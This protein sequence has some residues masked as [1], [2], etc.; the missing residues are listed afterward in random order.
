MLQIFNVNWSELVQRMPE[1]AEAGYDSLWLPPPAK[2]GSVFSVGYDLF[3]PFDLGDLNQRGTVATKYGSKAQLMQVIQTAHRFGIRV[4]L[5]N[6]V[7]HRGFDVP[8]YN[9]NTPTNLYPGLAPQDFHLQTV[10]GG[11]YVNWPDI[12]DFNTIWNIQNQPLSGL[13]DL[14][15]EPG[16]VNLNFGPT[17]GST[18]SKISYLRQPGNN[19]YYMDPALP[20]I[21][22]PWHPFNGSHGIPVVEDVNAYLMRSV[23]WILNETKCDGFRLDAVKHVPSGFFGDTSDTPNGYTGAIQAM[24]DYVHGYGSNVTGN[25][26]QETGGNRDSLFNTEA[27]RNDAL[28]FGEHLGQP[29]TFDEYLS[30]GMRLLNT[31]LANY[32][33]GVLGNPGGSLSGLDQRDFSP[34]GAYSPIQS[35]MYAQ[36]ADNGYAAHRELQNAYYFMHEGIPEVYSDGNNQTQVSPGQNAFPAIANANFLGQYADDAMPELCRL[37]HQFA[38]GGTWSRWSDTDIVAFER[39]DYR[40]G[41]GSNPQ[42]QDVALFAMND[43][44]GFP[45]DVSFDDGVSRSGDGYYGCGPVSN[46]RGVGLVVGF[47]PGTVLVQMARSSAG[48]DRACAHLLVH[49]A[50]QNKTLA[51]STANDPNPA[52]RLIYVGGQSLAQNGGALELLI[53]SGGY[54]IYALQPPEPSRAALA[55]TI[56]LRQQSQDAPRI[57]VFRQDGVNG[58]SNFN[59]AY[60]FRVRGSV[61]TSGNLL[62]MANV[63]NFTYSIDIPVVT[64]GPFD[65]MVKQD[66][67]AV[68]TLVKLD[69][70][71]DLN[72]Q[73]GL[74]GTNLNDLR[75]NPPGYAT[76]VFL[77]YE[78]ALIQLKSGPERFGS[79]NVASNNLVSPNAETFA[80]VVGG[81]ASVVTGS[82]FGAA[83]TNATARWVWHD[84]TNSVTALG[85]V[86]LTQRNP[87][88]PAAGQTV[89]IW[90]KVGYQFQINTGCL[91]YTTDG[92]EPLGSFGTGKGTTRMVPLVF[93]NHD[94]ATSSIDWWKGV[95]P[96]NAQI[97]GAQIRYKISLF[98]SGLAS[99]IPDSESSGSKYYGLVQAAI[100]NFNPTTARVWLHNDL[101]PLNTTNGLQEG[102]HIVRARSFL[103]R[104]GK[105]SSYS[106]FS[107]TFYYDAGPP[108]G[109][110]AF[111]TTDGSAINSSSYTVVVRTDA[112]V[113]GVQFNIEDSNA[114]NDD[115]VTGLNNGNGSTNGAAK[116]VN[117]TTVTPTAA[118]DSSYP[119]FP[120]EFRFNYASVPS[121]GT[122]TI[123][124]RL[125]KLTSGVLPDRVATLVRSVSTTAPAQILN[126]S[127]P[128]NGAL[129]VISPNNVTTVQACFTP[130]LTTNNTSLF[131]IYINGLLQPRNQYTIRSTA[132]CGAKLSTLQYF[133][134]NSIPGTNVIQVVYTNQVTL[135]DTHLV[136]VARPGDSDG[137]GMPDWMELV[138]GT[139][140][141]DANSVLRITSLTGPLLAWQSVSNVHYQ[142]LSTSNLNYPLL[143][144]SPVIPG[145][146][147][148][149]FY[150]DNSSGQSNHF[151]RI[152]VLPW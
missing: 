115:S 91:Y 55:D 46:S 34:S 130:S 132:V 23:M 17:M 83:L 26:Y 58:D 20:S 152:Q 94:S 125:S 110:I 41:S 107:Q 141:Y 87:I 122:A 67:S 74:G 88:N 104:T 116:Y 105:S 3:D 119:N 38:R 4:Y 54:V 69:G 93:S 61:D 63:S 144:L 81:A 137:D 51:T 77:G 30:R 114:N 27:P 113:T 7:N 96:A 31:P 100:T 52:N 111:P 150:Y 142:V 13:L 106:T 126:L 48:S 70:G 68:N 82:G 149:T 101:N 50:T 64:N 44:F 79:R 18:T 36:S 72:S 143:P 99:P 134:L 92:G 21:G 89:E 108:A 15:N 25:G 10:S 62:P 45:G 56:T 117:A 37:H 19:S 71:V 128:T 42:D 151:Y 24:F 138:A 75:D 118:L 43:K 133:W 60:P 97:A 14:A 53:P 39:Y 135:S 145:L 148:T 86:P 76:D 124:V 47:P 146:G 109:V 85:T 131:S 16:S 90:V 121:A 140:P 120:Q 84:P 98:Y 103:Q 2:A 8:R 123:R 33:N 112:N 22:G 139:N 65:I 102:Y 57:T 28:I 127:S 5:D 12:T 59:P 29:P 66:A 11:Y 1:I 6:I 73:M 35:I 49:G 9:A 80:Y 95:I 136:A 129:L 147:A 40:E 32:L 78:Q